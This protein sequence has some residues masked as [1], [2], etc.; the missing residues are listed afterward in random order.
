[1][2][3]QATPRVTHNSFSNNSASEQAAAA[4]LIEPQARPVFQGNVF[5]RRE[6]AVAAL[7]RRR[8]PHTTEDRERVSG[9]HG[10]SRP[11]SR[12]GAQRTMSD[13]M[14]GQIGPYIIERPIGHGGMASGLPGAGLAYGQQVALKVVHAGTD[15]DAKEILA[16]R[17]ARRRAAAAVLVRQRVRAEAF[18]VRIHGRLLLH[19][20]GVHRRR[21]PVAGDSSRTDCRGSA[22]CRSPIQLCEFLEDADRFEMREGSRQV[23]LHNDL[24]P[25][26]IRVMAGDAIKVLDFGAA[27]ALSL[28]RKVTRNDFG[29]TA[30]LSPECLESGDRDLHSDAVG[31]GVLLYEMVRGRQ[32]FRA[33]DTRRLEQLILSRQRPEALDDHCPPGLRRSSANCWRHIRRTATPA[34]PRFAKTLYACSTARYQTPSHRIRRQRAGPVSIFRRTLRPHGAR[35]PWMLKRQRDGPLLPRLSLP[36]R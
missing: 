7:H 35:P 28:S 19:R 26:N 32:P 31:V 1:V 4:M 25:R 2:R 22:R 13:T 9:H 29:S 21:R 33:D 16:G 14:F 10:H 27:K 11:R 5:P 24:K 36:R 18:R 8:C 20:D 12:P 17:T 3:A 15:E 6:S 30:Y 23:L 34:R